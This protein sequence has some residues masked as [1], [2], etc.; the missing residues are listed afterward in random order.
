[1][2][3]RAG[4][5]D[6]KGLAE[7]MPATQ[8]LDGRKEEKRPEGDLLD[9]FGGIVATP[10]EIAMWLGEENLVLTAKRGWSF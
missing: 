5:P 10:L 4:G 1:M 6:A 3:G 7:M 9:H 2:E 8:L